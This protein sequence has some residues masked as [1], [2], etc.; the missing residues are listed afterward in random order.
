MAAI[1]TA[2]AASLE[3]ADFQFLSSAQLNAIST[4]SLKEIT[5]AALNLLDATKFAALSTKQI[6]ALSTEQVSNLATSELV[7]MTTAQIAAISTAGIYAM[8]TTQLCELTSPQIQALTSTQ[9]SA[10]QSLTWTPLM[11]DLNGNGVQTLP[12]SA[13]VKFDVPNQGQVAGTGW[14]APT[15]GLL[16]MD[17]SGNGAIDDG[18]EL[19]GSGTLMPDGTQAVDGFAA[20]TVLDT[21][22]DGVINA[23]DTGFAALKVWVDANSDGASQSGEVIGLDTLGIT[24]LNLNATRTLD[25]D[26]GNMIGLTSS[27]V[28]ADGSNHTLADV[29]LAAAPPEPVTYDVGA[30]SPPISAPAP[31]RL[32]VSGMTQALGAYTESVDGIASNSALAQL[33][34]GGTGGGLSP[35][36]STLDLSQSLAIQLSSFIDQNSIGPVANSAISAMPVK[37]RLDDSASLAGVATASWVDDQLIGKKPRP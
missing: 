5:T 3:P 2:Q 10:L 25:F 14:V 22:N 19:F 1:T 20:L 32:N 23:K 13:G 7:A 24:A 8:T 28:T 4:A 11:L 26:N 6:A 21:N 18:S 15:D 37:P 33:P 12:L 31:L 16:V 35:R 29:W 17:R 34:S 9:I 27:Y 36:A 30:V